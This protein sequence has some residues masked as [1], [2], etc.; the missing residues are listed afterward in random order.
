V[1]I[2]DVNLCELPIKCRKRIDEIETGFCFLTQD[3]Q[4]RNFVTVSAVS[5][6]KVARI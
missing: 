1:R 4:G 6:I 2:K 5:G 3:K